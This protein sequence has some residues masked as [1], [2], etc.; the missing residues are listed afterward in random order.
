MFAK[1][2]IIAFCYT[3]ICEQTFLILKFWKNKYCWLSGDEHLNAI[4]RIPTTNMKV[5]INK[6]GEKI[7]PQKSY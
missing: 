2:I 5:D 6:L 3:Y 7:Q 1:K 4:L